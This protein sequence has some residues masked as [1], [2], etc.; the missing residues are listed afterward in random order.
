MRYFFH[1]TSPNDDR[2]RDESGIEAAN[3][4]AAKAEALRAVHEILAE[5]DEADENWS[6]WQLE[7]ADALER[8][9]FTIALD[10][11]PSLQY[12]GKQ[13]SAEGYGRHTLH[14]LMAAIATGIAWD[15]LIPLM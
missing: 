15:S 10:L 3:F 1:L 2:I 13:G 8:V 7:I 12:V 5:D 4:E 14:G 9:L 11:R 6:G